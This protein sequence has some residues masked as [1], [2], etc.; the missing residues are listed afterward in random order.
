MIHDHH[1][2][3]DEYYL[4]IDEYLNL[5]N[6][7]N[8]RLAVLSPPC[9]LGM[10]PK[11]SEL[12]YTIQR[13]LLLNNIGYY[14]AKL[15]SN[16]FY[17]NKDEL[18]LFWKIFS[19]RKN[20]KKISNPNNDILYK[21]IINKEKLKMWYWINPKTSK[22]LNNHE[23][24]IERMKNK[25]FGIKFHMYWHNFHINQIL[26]YQELANKYDFPIYIILNYMDPIKFVHF[27]KNNNFKKIIFGYGG[28]PLFTR[29]WENINNFENCYVDIASNHIDINIINK[30]FNTLRINKI[31]FSTDCPY[32][33]EDKNNMFDYKL[34]KSRINSER[35]NLI[36]KN[37][38]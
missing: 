36:L 21:K 12:M 15:I 27:L 29:C 31:I 22:S 14:L 16:S 25:I 17:N 10:E 9:T 7:N 23:R 34:F 5:L 30:I 37:K 26:K 35:L 19:G 6:T 20:L 24:N 8:I 38:L 2:Y 1:V 13:K 4:N 11:K 32:N 3:F 28:F 33:F 18:R